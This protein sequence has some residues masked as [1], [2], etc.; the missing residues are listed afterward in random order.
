MKSSLENPWSVG[1]VAGRFDASIVIPLFRHSPWESVIPESQCA[2]P[3]DLSPS[4]PDSPSA[5][6]D[7]EAARLLALRVPDAIPYRSVRKAADIAG[8]DEGTIRNILTGV[9]WPDLRTIVR[10]EKG[11]DIPLWP[12]R[13]AGGRRA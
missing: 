6:G 5:D 9:C 7:G 4:W 12:V 10:L 2:T 1:E 3:A 8:A 11:L 13:G